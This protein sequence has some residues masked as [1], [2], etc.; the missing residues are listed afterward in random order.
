MPSLVRFLV[1]IGVLV[2][3]IYGVIYA[4]ASFVEPTSRE[5]TITIPRDLLAKPR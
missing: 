2:G 3:L 4:L 1:I 5:M